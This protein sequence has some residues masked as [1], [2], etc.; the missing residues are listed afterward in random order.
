M[1]VDA[2]KN[3]KLGAVQIL[4]HYDCPGLTRNFSLRTIRSA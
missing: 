2:L 4:G 3:N 1:Y